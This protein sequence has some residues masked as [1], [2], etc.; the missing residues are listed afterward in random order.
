M[1]E[2]IECYHKALSLRPDDTFAQEM[3]TLALIDQCAVTMPPYK[4]MA[5][6]PHHNPLFPPKHFS[7]ICN[8][9]VP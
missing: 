8:P 5:Y 1:S 7:K 9:E 2:A 4:F 6:N 3:L